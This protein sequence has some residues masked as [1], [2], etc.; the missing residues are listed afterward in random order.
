VRVLA[1]DDER[2]ALDD[3]ARV[4]RGH[5]DVDEVKCAESGQ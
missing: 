4:L 5:E 1:V 2:P 3:L